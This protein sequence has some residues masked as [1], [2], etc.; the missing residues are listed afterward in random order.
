MDRKGEFEGKNLDEAL[1][2]ASGALG[3]PEEDL[4]YE[5][6]EQ[7]RRGVLG[8]GVKHVRILVKPP[9]DDVAA[10]PAPRASREKPTRREVTAEV[11]GEIEGT[12]QR[13]LDLIG[14]ELEARS[15]SRTGGVGLVL[16]GADRGVLLE[17]DGELLSALQFLLNRMARRAWPDV[18]RI[19]L[20][21]DGAEGSRRRDDDIADLA[22]KTAQQVAKTGQTKT[23]QPLNSYER[24]LVHLAVQEF[25][26]LTSVSDGQGALKR[27]RISKVRNTVR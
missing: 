24:R 16:D 7:G 8:M 1:E 13:M 20:A 22:R 17:R 21:C 2:A 4:H 5:I 9:L 18:G 25:N 3:I 10:E 14:L 11:A 23:M 19:N 12:L 6:L 26:G 15:A 27:V